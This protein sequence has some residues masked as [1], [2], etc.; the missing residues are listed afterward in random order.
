MFTGG[1][2]TWYVSST[3]TYG[4][5]VNSN[6][7]RF[8]VSND[9]S[10]TAQY[11]LNGNR[12]PA[13]SPTTFTWTNSLLGSTTL[14]VKSQYICWKYFYE[15]SYNKIDVGN[16]ATSYTFSAFNT[17]AVD[18]YVESTDDQDYTVKSAVQEIFIGIQPT[19]EISFPKDVN[20]RNSLEQVFTWELIEEVP[21]GQIAYEIG[22]KKHGDPETAWTHITGRSNSYHV[23]PANTFSTGQYDW[24]VQVTNKDLMVT[25]FAEA[26][27]T[28]IG[29]TD[30]PKITSVTN[31]SIPSINWSITSQDTFEVEIF[32]KNEKIYQS[33]IQVGNG[34]RTFKPNLMLEDGNYIIKMR[35][36]NEFGFFTK[37][38]E[39]AF[40]LAPQKP[41]PVE[42]RVYA[43]G[44]HGVNIT[45]GSGT[46][47][48][49]YVIRREFGK[50]G[51]KILGKLPSGGTFT[52]NTL[53]T[54]R[55]YEYALRNYNPNAGYADSNV[56]SMTLNYQGAIIYNGNKFVKLFKTEEEQFNVIHAPSKSYSYSHAIG[57]KYPVREASEWISHIV[58]LSCF[59]VFDEYEMLE[60]FYEGNDPLWYKDD[61]FS[62]KC[63]IDSIQIKETLLG[64]GYTI[65]ID[66]SRTD[67]EE[68][69][70]NA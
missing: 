48:T 31:S 12:I 16:K 24:R 28:A 45:K 4:Y 13:S 60:K 8:K 44:L 38:A 41:L 5:T 39:K 36:M 17:W 46:A 65:N 58:S 30:M 42:C 9:F 2:I 21:T 49:L 20:I 59:V 43:N 33:G 52:D 6:S 66:L 25:E 61:N 62:Y 63:S 19:V 7:L 40:I 55:K 69:N 23:F 64:R 37:W 3:D 51:W 26:T 35:A 15:T 47:Q 67:E 14:G 56:V 1:T 34:V 32:S 53:I 11:P 68:V 18:W 70:L 57:R 29:E 27:F 54:N 22:Y 10:V 50:T